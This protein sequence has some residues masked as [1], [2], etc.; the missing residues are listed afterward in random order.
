MN[1]TDTD[2]DDEPSI[3]SKCVA[4]PT[5]LA[6]SGD[7][8]KVVS[9]IF[10]R[11][12][13][14]TLELPNLWVHWCRKHYQRFKYRAEATGAWH[15]RQ[16]DLV[17]YQLQIFEDWGKVRSWTIVL[18]KAEAVALAKM[19]HEAKMRKKGVIGINQTTQC[20]E[21]FLLPYLGSNKTFAHVREVLEVIDRKFNEEDFKRRDNKLKMFPGVE[22]LP[23]IGK[24][25][26]PKKGAPATP[27]T[28]SQSAY[29]KITLDQPAF[30]RK[31]RANKEYLEKVARE[32]EGS[33]TPKSSRTPSQKAKSPDTDTLSAS[34]ATLKRKASTP[35]IATITLTD[36]TRNS[37]D[38]TFTSKEIKRTS[39]TS[40]P[41]SA[42]LSEQHNNE[43][44]KRRRLDHTYENHGSGSEGMIFMG[45]EEQGETGDENSP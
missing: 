22:F 35:D 40:I 44:T 43:P 13:K 28:K 41:I 39:P 5:C 8:R 19:N 27:A 7:H 14:C 15:L 9:H 31:N 42:L 6:N 10:G 12:K 21:S 37:L 2:T 24:A 34:P 36:R 23:V 16:L 32:V 1:Q 38:M 26:E 18:R 33:T 3:D 11:N 20:W 29:K 25:K 17:Y 45:K 30:N 4:V